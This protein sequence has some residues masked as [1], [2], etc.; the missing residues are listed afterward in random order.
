VISRYALGTWQVLLPPFQNREQ[1]RQ[2]H[3]ESDPGNAVVRDR[4]E[5]G[6]PNCGWY[7]NFWLGDGVRIIAGA[8]NGFNDGE[9]RR[10]QLSI[11]MTTIDGA[12]ETPEVGAASGNFE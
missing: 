8:Q 10:W 1:I 5:L 3:P 12:M 2:F 9:S 4:I 11:S 6:R 7:C